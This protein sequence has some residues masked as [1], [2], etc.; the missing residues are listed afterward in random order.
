[1]MCTSSRGMHGPSLGVGKS[2]ARWTHSS[3]S[4]TAN[5]LILLCFWNTHHNAHHTGGEWCP[6][7]GVGRACGWLCG[8]LLKDQLIVLS[9]Q[10]YAC[11]ILQSCLFLNLKE[12]W[13]SYWFEQTINTKYP[14]VLMRMLNVW[15]PF[16]KNSA[17]K[18]K[19][20]QKS[21]K[22]CVMTS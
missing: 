22:L 3:F 13:T 14:N 19:G 21:S 16:S 18:I 20:H 9:P 15:L 12:N 6:V 10:L 8:G 1:M 7:G 2:S 11:M 4:Q 17:K 5:L